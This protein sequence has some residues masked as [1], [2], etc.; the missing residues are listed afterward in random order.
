MF[1][2][3]TGNFQKIP[4]KTTAAES[5]FCK[6]AGIKGAA[7][8]ILHSIS[9]TLLKILRKYSDRLL[10]GHLFVNGFFLQKLLQLSYRQTLRKFQKL[11]GFNYCGS[12]SK[13]DKILKINCVRV[14]FNQKQYLSL[15]VTAWRMD[16]FQ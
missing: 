4:R 9:G 1:W 7:L 14:R 13:N 3:R 11:W 16:F 8:Q 6:V 15:T 12:Q 2:K 10:L 5:D